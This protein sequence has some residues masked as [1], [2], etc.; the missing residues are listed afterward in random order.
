[1]ETLTAAFPRYPAACVCAR[2]QKSYDVGDGWWS[3]GRWSD[4]RKEN[5]SQVLWTRSL[6]GHAS[7]GMVS[8]PHGSALRNFAPS[9]AA[10]APFYGQDPVVAD[11]GACAFF[12]PS[13]SYLVQVGA[14]GWSFAALFLSRRARPSDLVPRASRVGPVLA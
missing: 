10:A 13:T 4:H 12:D 9:G 1:M 7:R 8:V 6:S 11:R 3:F 14:G 5:S 2:G